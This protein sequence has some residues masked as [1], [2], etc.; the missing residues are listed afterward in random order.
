MF[1]VFESDGTPQ[2]TY[3]QMIAGVC[4]GTRQKMGFA[5]NP[6]N[7]LG[8]DS[9]SYL[10]NNS[11]NMSLGLAN[12]SVRTKQSVVGYR[13]GTA[14]YIAD[15]TGA[16]LQNNSGLNTTSD[17]FSVG[18]VINATGTMDRNEFNGKIFELL[19]YDIELS[20]ENIG[21]VN[22]YLTSKWNT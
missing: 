3:G 11:Q 1:V 7:G 14:Q 16:F 18:A 21:L 13:S 17:V 9:I 19:L 5:V 15:Q 6:S 22:N 20:K 4:G 10:N 2:E 12:V 8:T